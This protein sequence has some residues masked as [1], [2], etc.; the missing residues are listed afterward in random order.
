MV[1]VT[2][3]AQEKIAHVLKENKTEAKGVRVFLNGGG[4]GG[5]SLN[6]ALDESKDSDSVFNNGGVQYVID[7]D[8]LKMTGDI[9]IDFVTEG[10]QFGFTIQSQNPVSGS[11]SVDG[12]CSSQGGC[13]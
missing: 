7:N 12:T 6:L 10:W 2:E 3:I 11:C 9:T 1:T 4:W 13:S 5:P 8:I